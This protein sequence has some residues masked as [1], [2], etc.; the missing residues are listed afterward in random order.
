MK[1]TSVER[2]RLIVVACDA[3]MGSSAMG[4]AVL[5][6]KIEAAGLHIEVTNAAINDLKDA[7]IVIL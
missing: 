2:I 5:R 3:G 1:L 4:A 6:R 7:D